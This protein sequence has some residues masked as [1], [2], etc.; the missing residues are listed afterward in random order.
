M[1]YMINQS[2]RSFDPSPSLTKCPYINVVFQKEKRLSFLDVFIKVS[3]K[4]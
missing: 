3:L 2:A 4:M 1:V